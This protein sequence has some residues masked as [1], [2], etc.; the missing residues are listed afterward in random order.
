VHTDGETLENEHL[1]IRVDAASGTFSIRTADG[2]EVEG[3][4]RLV[5]G[6]DG[7]DTYNYSPPDHDLVIDTPQ[8]VRVSVVE[9][10]PLRA[11]LLV[12]RRYELPSHAIGDERRCTER[13][14][15]LVPVPIRTV[16]ELRTGERFVR[17]RT[18]LDHHERD[19]RLRAHFPLPATVDGSDAECAYTVV[20]RGLDAESGPQ[21]VGLATFPSR[22]FVNCSDGRVGMAI[23]HRGLHEYEVLRDGNGRGRELAITILRATGFLSRAEPAL[24]PVP[25]GPLLPAGGAQLAGRHVVEYAVLL[26]HGDWRD[27]ACHDAVD[28]YD[29]DLLTATIPGEVRA[30]R[31]EAHPP[32][33]QALHVD[34]AQVAALRR[35]DGRLI[36]RLFNPRPDTVTAD[37]ETDGHPRAGRVVDLVGGFVDS[38]TGS[39]AMRPG[40][41]LT[42]EL[43]EP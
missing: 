14:T 38:F 20:H 22:R 1:R 21:E 37:V 6:G 24:R 35:Q 32:T 7:G 15:T 30:D 19:H 29:A 42:L 40:Q 3:L 17:I 23:L 5:D 31:Q 27:G 4:D 16:L 12:E 2:I 39:V 8:S 25:A 33:G 18:E 13:V 43:D 11:C 36:V 26:H 41:I 9:A 28:A 10:G 34:G